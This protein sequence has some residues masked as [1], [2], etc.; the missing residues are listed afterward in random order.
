MVVL[1]RKTKGW[2]D[3]MILGRASAASPARAG[4]VLE[5]STVRTKMLVPTVANE[6][7]ARGKLR[8][9]LCRNVSVTFW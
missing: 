7:V 5:H 3:D 9:T 1:I 8:L 6:S 4:C 2:R